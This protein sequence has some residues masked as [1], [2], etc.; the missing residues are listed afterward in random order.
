M[1]L[2]A[3]GGRV[4]KLFWNLKKASCSGFLLD[5]IGRIQ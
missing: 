4:E 5:F 1:Y 2:S 3:R